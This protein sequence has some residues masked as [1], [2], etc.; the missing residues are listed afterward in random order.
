M[1][2]NDY[3]QTKA[4]WE[5]L[6]EL[7]AERFD[8]VQLYEAGL[9]QFLS[10][11][12]HNSSLLEI[13]CGPGNNTC[14]FVKNRPDLQITATDFAEKMVEYTQNRFPALRVKQLDIR[15][16]NHLTEIYDSICVG[17]CF[18][19]ITQSDV[20]LFFSEA[21]NRISSQGY[22]Y[23]SFVED[24]YEKSGLQTNSKGQQLHFHYYE[25][26]QMID[27]AKDFEL[28]FS[29]T[30]AYPIENPREKHTALL[31]KKVN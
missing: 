21:S 6:P 31:F 18:P 10:L 27:W 8:D 25:T 20:Q 12:P 17:F 4:V 1:N 13:G 16:L 23:V 5:T 28:V 11:L 15:N 29:D 24:N 26:F 22:L 19:Y 3:L 7:Y 30:V 2:E 14:F 9:Q